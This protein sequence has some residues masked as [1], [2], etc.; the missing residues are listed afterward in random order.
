MVHLDGQRGGCNSWRVWGYLS[1]NTRVQDM[2]APIHV[3]EHGAKKGWA[4]EVR[5]RDFTH[6]ALVQRGRCGG[7]TSARLNH[8]GWTGLS[9][10]CFMLLKRGPPYIYP[11]QSVCIEAMYSKLVGKMILLAEPATCL[12][13]RAY[14]QRI[15]TSLK[16]IY[17]VVGKG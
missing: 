10:E 12:R 6:A 1:T 4:R 5:Q 13:R 9:L 16:G 7:T 8:R 11:T 2:L 15:Y 3:V 17:R 14:K